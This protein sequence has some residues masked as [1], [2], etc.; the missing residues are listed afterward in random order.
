MVAAPAAAKS[1]SDARRGPRRSLR[2]ETRPVQE[3]VVSDRTGEAGC[4]P[5]DLSFNKLSDSLR[6]SSAARSWWQG[7]WSRSSG[8]RAWFVIRMPGLQSAAQHLCSAL[9]ASKWGMGGAGGSRMQLARW[10]HELVG[11]DLS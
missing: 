9:Q 1:A 3:E 7:A 8:V 4:A 2:G 6:A 11:T 10:M 5:W